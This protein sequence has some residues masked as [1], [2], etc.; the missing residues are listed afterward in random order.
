MLHGLFGILQNYARR[1]RRL[2]TNSILRKS[3]HTRTHIRTRR[4]LLLYNY[5]VEVQQVFILGIM[6]DLYIL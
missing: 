6:G 1:R 5:V 2:E 4:S 3:K